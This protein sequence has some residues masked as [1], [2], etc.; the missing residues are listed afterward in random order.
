MEELPTDLYY[1]LTTY[2]DNLSLASLSQSSKH[3]YRILSAET[4]WKN[5]FDLYFSVDCIAFDSVD[6]KK[7]FIREFKLR[8]SWKNDSHIHEEPSIGSPVVIPSRDSCGKVTEIIEHI[9]NYPKYKIHLY[10]IKIEKRK[11][12]ADSDQ[13]DYDDDDDRFEDHKYV[14]PTDKQ[15]IF[16]SNHM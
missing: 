2:L 13:S 4:V 6:W 12:E 10:E 9:P 16:P 5:R 14:V 3:F 15:V 7:E 8:Q 1:Y 11:Y